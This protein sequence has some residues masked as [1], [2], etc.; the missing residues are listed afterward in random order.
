MDLISVWT[1]VGIGLILLIG[2]GIIGA[3]IGIWIIFKN[4]KD[5]ENTKMEID[6]GVRQEGKNF[7][8]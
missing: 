3:G 8:L 1:I 2:L 4:S 7:R 6:R 5:I